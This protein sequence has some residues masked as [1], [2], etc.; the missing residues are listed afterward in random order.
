MDKQAEGCRFE[1]L[2]FEIAGSHGQFTEVCE[3]S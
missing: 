2:V 1:H 3:Q